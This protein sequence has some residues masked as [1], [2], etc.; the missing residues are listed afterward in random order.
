MSWYEW[1][2]VGLAGVLVYAVGFVVAV[3]WTARTCN[4][5]GGHVSCDHVW[6]DPFPA[7][8]PLVVVL[9]VGAA[10]VWVPMVLITKTSRKVDRRIVERR[11]LSQR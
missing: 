1:V 5:R 6:D 4:D 8:W 10:P 11:S 9:V 3:A 7:L 2:A